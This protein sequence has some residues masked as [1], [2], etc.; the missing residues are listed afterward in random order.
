MAQ[1]RRALQEPESADHVL[2]LGDLREDLDDEIDVALSVDPS[3]NGQAHQYQQTLA[4]LSDGPHFGI[5]L[6]GPHPGHMLADALSDAARRVHLSLDVSHLPDLWLKVRTD[7]LFLD[8]RDAVRTAGLD[9][10]G[11]VLTHLTAN[12][13]FKF[14]AASLTE[15]LQRMNA[16]R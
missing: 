7:T 16:G 14:D 15:S 5:I 9:Q 11:H 4:R 6:N 1:A 13:V 3:R 2:A 12:D 10:G 8:V